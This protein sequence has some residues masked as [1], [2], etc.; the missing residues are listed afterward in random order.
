M[1]TSDDVLFQFGNEEIPADQTT[2]ARYLRQLKI[3]MN[4]GPYELVKSFDTD[5]LEDILKHEQ[6]LHV[7]K[8]QVDKME[9]EKMELKYR[10]RQVM[11]DSVDSVIFLPEEKEQSDLFDRVYDEVER[12]F[13]LSIEKGSWLLTKQF[14]SCSR[15]V[16]SDGMHSMVSFLIHTM[17]VIFV[18]YMALVGKGPE[19]QVELI[20]S[21]RLED[22]VGSR[23]NRKLQKMFQMNPG[24]KPIKIVLIGTQPPHSTVA[25]IDTR[26]HKRGSIEYFEPNM[27]A[28]KF[29]GS[30]ELDS[31]EMVTEQI[32]DGVITKNVKYLAPHVK[33]WDVRLAPMFR[34][35][36]NR[37]TCA[38]W[39]I[40]Y[41]MK[42][43]AGASIDDLDA[44]SHRP[45]L[46]TV[47]RQQVSIIS[48]V[49]ADILHRS[50][51]MFKGDFDERGDIYVDYNRAELIAWV[52]RVVVKNREDIHKM[53][54][55]KLGGTMTDRFNKRVV[56]PPD[57]FVA[58]SQSSSSYKPTFSMPSSIG[59]NATLI[60]HKH[61]SCV[62]M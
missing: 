51:S 13:I 55:V 60:N 15:S 39:V 19:R 32:R 38:S 56:K 5:D 30:R 26:D 28:W 9:M 50:L 34:V 48:S 2:R 43:M 59:S 58:R 14:N 16:A 44:V 21:I 40:W 57:R 4:A 47:E 7:K 61:G 25:I 23:L 45:E 62:V 46:I 8:E 53:F 12:S 6:E 1:D 17:L 49:L 29:N 31:G 3:L 54:S 11:D 22:Q 37:G 41:V 27:N 36:G 52:C 24:S 35:Q 10:E 20:G 18:D 33:S 42:R